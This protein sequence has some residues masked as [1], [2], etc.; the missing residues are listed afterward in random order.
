MDRRKPRHNQKGKVTPSRTEQGVAGHNFLL[1]Y[2]ERLTSQVTV[3]K[4]SGPKRH[5]YSVEEAKSLLLPK[6]INIVQNVSILPRLAMPKNEIVAILTLHPSYIAKSYFPINFL[7]AAGFKAIGSRYKTLKPRKS[8]IKR[9]GAHE[10]TTELYVAGTIDAFSS[11]STKIE[12]WRPGSL[13]SED[14][15]KIED[16]YLLDP[17]SKIIKPRSKESHQ[18]YEIVIHIPPG[19]KP[20]IILSAFESYLESLK[21]KANLNRRIHTM[22][23]C[24]IP[25]EMPK[26][27]VEE[28]AKFS[29]LR[30]IRSMPKLR[31]VL[32]ILRSAQ[33]QPFDCDLPGQGPINSDIRIAVLDGGLPQRTELERWVKYYKGPDL[34]SEVPEYQHHGFAVT[35]AVLFGPLEQD[36]AIDVPYAGVDHYCVL[37]SNTGTSSDLFDVLERIKTIVQSQRYEFINLSLG[38]DLPIEDDQVHAWTAVIDELLA[39]NKILVAIAAGNG[40]ENDRQSGNARIQVP[41]DCVNAL[42]I[43]ASNSRGPSWNRAPYSSVGPGRSPGYI[44]PDVMAFGGVNTEP[45]WVLN[46]QSPNRSFATYGTS[47]SAPSALRLAVG[48]RALFGNTISPLALKAL[49]IH[50]SEDNGHARSDVGWGRIP[51][52]IEDIVMCPTGAAHILYQGELEPAKY[53]RVPIPLPSGSLQGLINIRC[54]LCFTTEIDPAHPIHY[55]RGGLEVIFRP[56]KD[57]KSGPEKHAKSASFFSPDKSYLTEGELRRQAFKWETVFKAQ[58]RL[59]ASSLKDP[60]L[61]VHYIARAEGHGARDPKRIPYA[62]VITID[63]PN[64]PNLYDGIVNRYRTQLEPLQ[65]VIEIPI[66][67]KGL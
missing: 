5:P 16:M 23:L 57:S 44:K 29:Y 15:R 11:L 32:P 35:S 61:D 34:A 33:A 17:E 2:G 49:L 41:S 58:K 50:H 19:E 60:V 28:V 7:K 56:H 20:D 21:V 6:A 59:R 62:F 42:A 36:K 40:G 31:P 43:G 30:V 38:P 9:K 37:D 47:F 13:E 63:A 18:K 25:L 45:F 1:G 54:T 46:Y 55:T 10:L 48:V 26:D 39:E 27:R 14:L 67:N 65:P 64:N 52:Q 3:S 4:G 51:N 12:R 53:L 8:N 22:G 66:E 24:F